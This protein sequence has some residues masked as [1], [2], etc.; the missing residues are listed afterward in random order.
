MYG[1]SETGYAVFASPK[2]ALHGHASASGEARGAAL[3]PAP[4]QLS[5]PDREEITL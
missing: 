1:F 5:L 2:L 4:D 3:G